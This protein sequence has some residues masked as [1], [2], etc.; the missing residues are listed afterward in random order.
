[1]R[2]SALITTADLK[3]KAK[4]FKRKLQTKRLK[5]K[6]IARRQQKTGKK[7]IAISSVVRK[8]SS[9]KPQ[10]KYRKVEDF[11]LPKTFSVLD[12]PEQALK[13]IHQ[14]TSALSSRRCRTVNLNYE[15]CRSYSLG[16]EALL[17]IL[18]R[19]IRH[20]KR[21]VGRPVTINGIYPSE[22]NHTE[23]VR[24]IGIV[25]EIDADKEHRELADT[26]K[27]LIFIR[28]KTSASKGSAFAQDD[29]NRVSENFVDYINQCLLKSIN[30]KLT[31]NAC[32]TLASC[33][34]ELLDNAER[35]AMNKQQ[36]KWYIRAHVNFSH[37]HPSCEIVIFNFGK[38]IAATYDGLTS[39]H[40]SYSKQVKPYVERHLGKNGLTK[41]A[42]ITVAS[43]QGRVSC[44]NTDERRTCGTGTVELL[45]FFQELYDDIC[46]SD[47]L[48]NQ[49]LKPLMT[50]M[51]GNVWIKFDGTYRL[52]FEPNNK[53]DDCNVEGDFLEKAV[54]P[55]NDKIEGL[56][57]PPDTDFVQTLESGFF[58]GVM[59]NIR[60]PLEI[61]RN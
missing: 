42:L 4:Q 24:D 61:T 21:A 7:P 8:I 31:N 49:H 22:S 43:L 18:G 58:P 26:G 59:I 46:L 48:N 2:K 3:R 47:R 54:Y 38:T 6:R 34:S 10:N 1:M 25:K 53:D 41:E 29:K 17:G 60:F 44:R 40:F 36:G 57:E 13:T 11:L 39:D 45:N 12:D 27:Q 19:V 35:H 5:R 56:A 30:R 14:I 50:L 9:D 20:Q 28:E 51:S 32:R 15:K 37:E 55:L 52:S 33:V 16:S 23:I